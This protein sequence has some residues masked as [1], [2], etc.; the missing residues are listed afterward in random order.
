MDV[1][2]TDPGKTKGDAEVDVLLENGD[3]VIAV[4]VKSKPNDEDVD[5]HLQRMEILRRHA[6]GKQ[7]KR[8][9]QGAIA[10]AVMSDEVRRYI[11]KKGLYV[12]EQTGDTVR[13]SIPPGFKAHEW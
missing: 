13:I 6:D 12:I 11:E 4:E 5:D 9:Y 8:R 3:I 7:D 10:G 2:Y 1:K